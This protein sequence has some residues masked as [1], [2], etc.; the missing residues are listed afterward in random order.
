MASLAGL[1][2][3]P[4]NAAALSVVRTGAPG[5][6]RSRR[7][8]AEFARMVP[9]RSRHCAWRLTAR[10]WKVVASATERMQAPAKLATHVFTPSLALAELGDPTYRNPVSPLT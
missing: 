3:R 5:R 4:S 9:R 6:R 2:V 1:N 7:S 8:V 10:D